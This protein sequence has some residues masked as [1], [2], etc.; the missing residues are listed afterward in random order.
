MTDTITTCCTYR[1][2]LSGSTDDQ[3]DTLTAVVGELVADHHDL[4]EHGRITRH[5]DAITHQLNLLRL[6]TRRLRAAVRKE[7]DSGRWAERP[8]DTVCAEH[9]QAVAAYREHARDC[10]DDVQVLFILH[11]GNLPQ[12]S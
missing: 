4:L 10:R 6:M 9:A 12:T 8:A 5:P 2:A 7:R 3:R 1:P 11:G